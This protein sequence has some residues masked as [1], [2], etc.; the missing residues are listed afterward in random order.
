MTAIMTSKANGQWFPLPDM[1]MCGMYNDKVVWRAIG[2]TRKFGIRLKPETMHMLF[3]APSS[4]LYTDFTDFEN[5]VG[6]AAN[7]WWSNW[8]KHPM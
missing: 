7:L 5:I 8:Q 4:I 3:K 2:T 1:L 6:N